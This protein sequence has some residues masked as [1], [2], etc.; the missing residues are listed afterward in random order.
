MSSTILER[1]T[2][3]APLGLELRDAAS[4]HRVTDGLA[5]RV[6]PVN[7]PQRSVLA[8]ANPSG[9]FVAHDLPGLGDWS[10]GGAEPVPHPEFD[11]QVDDPL[12]R[13]LPCRLRLALPEKG[14]AHPVCRSDIPLFSA[15][16]RIAPGLAA[17][18]AD[19]FNLTAGVAA[20][21]AVVEVRHLGTSV[22]L[23]MTDGHGRLLL[24]FPYPEPALSNQPLAETTW[25]LTLH[26][27]H[28]PGLDSARPPE[29]CQALA[30]PSALFVDNEAPLT[31]VP[32]LAVTLRVGQ[33]MHATHPGRSQLYITP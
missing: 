32:L 17:I 21:W 7:H 8:Q 31:T 20:A 13:F 26:V 12:G 9:I 23:G 5:V 11:I 25:P 22:C 33:E 19:L 28:Q 4:G 24:A 1:V 10:K 3:L 6:A 18:R 16:T 2:R 14:L 27:R 30:Q 15:P 29:L